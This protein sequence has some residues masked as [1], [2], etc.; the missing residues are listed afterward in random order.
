MLFIALC[1]RLRYVALAKRGLRELLVGPTPLGEFRQGTGVYGLY[2][3]T[4][5]VDSAARDLKF[6][7]QTPIFFPQ[8]SPSCGWLAHD[9]SPKTCSKICIRQSPWTHMVM[10]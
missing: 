5:D 4:V 2:K 1:V 9:D 6:F 10:L 8:L 7:P 3:L